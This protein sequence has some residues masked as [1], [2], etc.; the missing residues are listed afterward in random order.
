MAGKILKKY[1]KL[2][3]VHF[4]VYL[5]AAGDAPFMDDKLE[6]QYELIQP[7]D[8]LTFV[9]AYVV[10]PSQFYV[11][12]NAKIGA[13]DAMMER[14]NAEL[15]SVSRRPTANIGIGQPCCTLYSDDRRWYRAKIVSTDERRRGD[16]CVEFVDYGNTETVAANVVHRLPSHYF[17]LPV[18]AVQCQLDEVVP[19]TGS[20]WS[21]D[22]AAHFE[23]LLGDV[24]HAAKVVRVDGS[25][26]AVEMKSV[27]R[28][29][30]ERRFAKWKGDGAAT[31]VHS[32]QTSKTSESS[33]SL[34]QLEPKK[35]GWQDT[36]PVS[37]DFGP[38]GKSQSIDRQNAYSASSKIFTAACNSVIN[39]RPVSGDGSGGF[40]SRT[41]NAPVAAPTSPTPQNF[42]PMNVATNVLQ[43]VVISW[44]VSPAEFYCQLVDNR[45]TIEQLSMCLCETYQLTRDCMLSA[46]DCTPGRP[47]VAYYEH[48]RNWYRGRIVSRAGDKVT[49]FYVDY[50]NTEVVGVGRVQGATAQLLK[51][52]PMQAV[53]CSLAAVEPGAFDQALSLP[54]LKCKFLNMHD[55]AYTV[56]LYDQSGCAFKPP[57]AAKSPPAAKEKEISTAKSY[58]HKHS[59]KVN[60]AVQLEVVYVADGS[61][62]F[63]CHIL[64]Q[65]DELDTLMADLATVCEGH[66]ALASFPEVGQPCAALYSED[67]SWYRA[68]VDSI[69]AGDESHR[70]VKFVDYGNIESCD[71]SSLRALDAKFL[72]VPV[73]RVDCRLN[74]MTA[75]SLNDVIDDLLGQQFP[76]TVVAVDRDG[77]VAVELKQV[78][79]DELFSATHGELFA[80]ATMSLPAEVPPCDP[81]DV[82]ITHVTSPSDFYL[83]MASVENRLTELADSLVEVYDADNSDELKLSNLVVGDLCC[84]RYSVDGSW[85]RA[86]VESVAADKLSVR[87]VDYGN[88]DEVSQADVRRLTERFTAIPACAWHCQF[89]A[90]QS[91]SWTDES[92]QK[93]VDLAA[94]GEKLFV[95]SFVSRSSSPFP[96]LLK[97]DDVDVGTQLF[98]ILP[99]TESAE[100]SPRGSEVVLPVAV[101]P[102]DAVDVCITFAESPSD[103]YIQ[104]A[105]VEDELSD[106]ADELISEYDSLTA[107]DRRLANVSVGGLCCAKYSADGAWYRATISEIVS[108]GE[109]RVLFVDYGN[110]D[111][112]STSSEVK[113]L[114]EKF[115]AKP[116]FAFRCTLA[117][118]G[119]VTD[120]ADA[121]KTKFL[122]LTVT[123]DEVPAVFSCQFLDQDVD[124]GRHV[125]SLSADGV[126]MCSKF[127]DGA[128]TAEAG[129]VTGDVRSYPQV[130]IVPG[131]HQVRLTVCVVISQNKFFAVITWLPLFGNSWKPENL[132]EFR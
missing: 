71:V 13:L 102:S 86:V 42:T 9:A 57:V 95:C 60:D 20:D 93:L 2:I 126:D 115:C 85:Y 44:V 132:R 63:N 78:D 122:E 117:G 127:T 98:G 61:N 41:D 52:P 73:C 68:V 84:A 106:L 114:A 47:C 80:R 22:A 6:F 51:S 65:T 99:T 4:C 49:V 121:E 59:L 91:F 43:S 105:S 18:Q 27:A 130:D 104:L 28:K 116:P 1:Y 40:K 34:R 25:N 30:V 69:P 23:E 8:D 12:M 92:K 7:H 26:H 109:V 53:K 19:I 46:A 100:P 64:G 33:A 79:G 72:H 21:D 124:T 87:F 14:L 90:M 50:G 11:H 29:L 97:D 10:S 83:Q 113:Q 17:E 3:D 66:A 112:V 128:V 67:G 119:P 81:V 88:S 45:R 108:A 39:S 37:P 38:G 36:K 48:D 75:L 118:V 107:D 101:P 58:V 54:D 131:K 120:C 76:A 32:G 15:G 82:Y 70:V 24:V 35:A 5:Q 55:G 62:V 111:V 77:T 89:N 96:V 125:V 110:S 123:E 103:F 16:L 56:E 74:G 31:V 94:A 129:E